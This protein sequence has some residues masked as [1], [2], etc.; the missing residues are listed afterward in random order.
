MIH[1]GC[2]DASHSEHA[3]ACFRRVAPCLARASGLRAAARPRLAA[4]IRRIVAAS[5][6]QPAQG[7]R[8]GRVDSSLD[9]RL[10]G[11]GKT[12]L[13]GSRTND[14]VQQWPSAPPGRDRSSKGRSGGPAST[15]QGRH[16][17]RNIALKQPKR[18]AAPQAH[19]AR[20]AQNARRDAIPRLSP[21]GKE[22]HSALIKTYIRGT[23]KFSL[24]S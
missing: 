19:A 10:Q 8:L 4:L 2:V 21:E 16:P 13:P 11:Q 6:A 1:A 20:N 12:I 23:N 3:F 18:S 5:T 17:G 24:A 22:I 14:R 9:V 15:C 7:C